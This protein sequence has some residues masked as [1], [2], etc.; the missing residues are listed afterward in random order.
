MA[1]SC[2]SSVGQVRDGWHSY[3]CLKLNSAI[4][5]NPNDIY[6]I[7]GDIGTPSGSGLDFINGFVFLERFYTVYDSGTPSFSIGETSFT[8]AV[9]N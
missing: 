6:L 3:F 2:E 8:F 5:G 1:T 4:G 7:V 9:T